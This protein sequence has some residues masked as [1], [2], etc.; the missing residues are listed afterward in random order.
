MMSQEQI[1]DIV[2]NSAGKLSD[3]QCRVLVAY[4]IGYMRNSM[5]ELARQEFFR[6]V[7]AGIEGKS[8]PIFP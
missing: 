6:Q 3:W 2:N 5:D 7:K 8:I 1:D 4:M